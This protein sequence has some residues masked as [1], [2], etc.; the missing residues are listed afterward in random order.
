MSGVPQ[1]IHSQTRMS[2]RNRSHS[3]TLLSTLPPAERYLDSDFIIFVANI[4]GA[5]SVRKI[6]SMLDPPGGPAAWIRHDYAK[7]TLP[8]L[9][10]VLARAS[11]TAATN[12][13]TMLRVLYAAFISCWFYRTTYSCITKAS[14]RTGCDF[15]RQRRCRQLCLWKW[16][17]NSYIFN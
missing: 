17:A 12:G 9:R 3:Q 4:D 16:L 8:Y 15:I 13:L 14:S 11:A 5:I 10:R 1:C 2:L 6:S 7:I